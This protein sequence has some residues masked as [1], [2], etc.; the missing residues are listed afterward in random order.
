MCHLALARTRKTQHAPPKCC[1]HTINSP[2]DTYLHGVES[3]GQEA[4]GKPYQVLPHLVQGS[5]RDVQHGTLAIKRIHRR[6][7]E[8]RKFSD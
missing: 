8:V 4:L 2:A 6:M 7:T 3:K 1:M 5:N